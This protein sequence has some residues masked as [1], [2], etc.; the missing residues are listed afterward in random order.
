MRDSD[1]VVRLARTENDRIGAFRL[2]YRVFAEEFGAMGSGIDHARRIESYVYDANAEHLILVD[3]SSPSAS[4]DHIV[5]TCRLL[6]RA[7]AKHN[8]HGFY[9]S[10][11][12]DLGRLLTR[13]TSLLEIGRSCLLPAHRNGST[14]YALWTGLADYVLTNNIQILFGVASFHGTDLRIFQQPLSYL[15][16]HH[17]APPDL[18]VASLASEDW[19]A[20]LLP[21]SAIVRS[22]ALALMPPLIKAYLR[23]GASVGHGAFVD[24][25]FRTVDVCVIVDTERMRQ[26]R[27][28]AFKR[29][30]SGR[31]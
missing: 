29:Q 25:A 4:H 24:A 17:L 5:G 13:E 1:I 7:E 22:Q 23:L 30:L 10:T 15:H 20:I 27:Q 8:A 2:R 18:R 3:R 12:F 19:Q 16:C 28:E 21:R 31:T 26:N 9:S 11:E 14:L 6:A